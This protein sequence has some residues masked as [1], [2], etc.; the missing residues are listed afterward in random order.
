[1]MGFGHFIMHIQTQMFH[2]KQPRYNVTLPNGHGNGAT[3][4]SQMFINLVTVQLR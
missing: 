1:M 3:L 4:L 2:H